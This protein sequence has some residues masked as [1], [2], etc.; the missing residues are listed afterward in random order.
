MAK[1][2]TDGENVDRMLSVRRASGQWLLLLGKRCSLSQV[3]LHESI[4]NAATE[5]NLDVLCRVA[6]TKCPELAQLCRVLQQHNNI[7]RGLVCTWWHVFN[8]VVNPLLWTT[9]PTTTSVLMDVVFAPGYT[10]I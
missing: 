7:I 1:K 10:M 4:E 3:F 2:L 6:Q 5:G 8:P 9:S